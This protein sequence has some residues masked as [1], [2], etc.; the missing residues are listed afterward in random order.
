MKAVKFKG[1]KYYD[2]K[3]QE[4]SPNKR[5]DQKSRAEKSDRKMN[6]VGI[7]ASDKKEPA[8]DS[9]VDTEKDE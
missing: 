7:T 3:G 5:K 4:I 6:D 8:E 9:A 2:E 1:G